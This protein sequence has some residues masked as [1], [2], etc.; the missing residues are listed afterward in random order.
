MGD[1]VKESNTYK[2]ER[3]GGSERIIEEVLAEHFPNLMRDM[4]VQM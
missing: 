3:T 1:S 2:D 4:N